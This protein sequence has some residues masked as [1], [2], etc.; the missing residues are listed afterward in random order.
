MAGL[1]KWV[2]YAYLLMYK[3]YITGQIETW[4]YAVNG[5]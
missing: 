4:D 5:M 2:D 3:T 1:A